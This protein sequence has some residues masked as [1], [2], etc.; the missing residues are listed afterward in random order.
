M[1][2]QIEKKIVNV[3][4][5]EGVPQGLE[6]LLDLD[7]GC[8]FSG[9]R[10]PGNDY[11]FHAV[12]AFIQL[13]YGSVQFL[14]VELLAVA[15]QSLITALPNTVGNLPEMHASVINRPGESF[16]KFPV[17]DVVRRIG[18]A[19]AAGPLQGML[20]SVDDIRLSSLGVAPFDQRL[21][22]EILDLLDGGNTVLP[23]ALF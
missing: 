12:E 13:A 17:R 23:L 10:R 9:R 22:D 15:D 14:I 6:L 18:E 16:P 11:H 4:R 2:L 3:Y 7:G 20:V 21:L 8:G 1:L 5:H 19:L